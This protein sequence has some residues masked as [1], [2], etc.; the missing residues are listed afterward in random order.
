MHRLKTI[1][2]K[3]LVLILS[4]LFTDGGR[5]FS[6]ISGNVKVI[7]EHDRSA[8]FEL[9]H[10]LNSVYFNT[11]EKWVE[12]LKIDLSCG[13]NSIVKFTSNINPPKG[14][15]SDSIWQPPKPV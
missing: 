14:D 6:A 9:P 5:S 4:L 1:I 7:L 10:Q 3:L 11:E 2:F 13:K 15:F 8:D 12:S